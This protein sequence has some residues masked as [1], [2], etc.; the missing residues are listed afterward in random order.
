MVMASRYDRPSLTAGSRSVQIAMAQERPNGIRE[1]V[2]GVQD[3]PSSAH[4]LLQ[5]RIAALDDDPAAVASMTAILK[6][7][8]FSV[9]SYTDADQLESAAR[10]SPFSAYVLDWYL[11]NTTAAALIEFLRHHPTSAGAPIFLLSGNLAIGGIPTDD[12]LARIIS[13][14][15]VQYRAK[16]YSGLRLAADLRMAL[17]ENED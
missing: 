17:G 1:S 2:S 8:G 5:P 3:A 9:V 7:S 10:S 15:N 12:A 4:A 14:H 11:G 13:R 6:Q 16:P